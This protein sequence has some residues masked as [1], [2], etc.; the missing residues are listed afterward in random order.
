MAK[1]GLTVST[2]LDAL[3]LLL[4]SSAN[5]SDEN[6]QDVPLLIDGLCNS[7]LEEFKINPTMDSILNRKFVRLLENVKRVPKGKEHNVERSKLVIDFIQ[8]NRPVDDDDDT[9]FKSLKQVFEDAQTAYNNTDICNTTKKRIKNTL[10]W[11][12]YRRLLNSMYNHLNK[13]GDTSDA[14]TQATCLMN[15]S[16]VAKKLVESANVKLDDICTLAEERIIVNDKNSL[17]KA[18]IKLQEEET[19]GILK[20][21]LQG[22]NRMLGYRGGFARGEFVVI[23]GLQH[24]YKTGL[25]LT[26]T[27]GIC[28]YNDPKDHCKPGMKPLILF[29]SLENYARKNLYWFYKTAWAVCKGTKPDPNISLEEM[30]SFIQEWYASTGWHF[31]IERYRGSSFGHEQL[32]ETIDNYK[33]LGYEVV[34]VCLDYMSKM[35]RSTGGNKDWVDLGDLSDGIF[36]TIKSDE[37]LFITP[38]QFNRD[39]SKIAEQG[40]TNV[41]KYFG[42]S[43]VS[44][45]LEVARNADLEISV[46]IEK[47]HNKQSWL[48]VQRG[49]HRYVDDTPEKHK[50]FAYKFDPDLGI[51]DD[52]DD[53]TPRFVEDIYVLDGTE[54]AN[55]EAPVSAVF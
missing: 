32:K 35:K 28:R 31:I 2:F 36:N 48:T 4:I 49:K 53:E 9:F 37:I 13:F 16:S 11:S 14:E 23:Y 8:N 45:S 1:G 10:T 6:N 30:I 18:L 25:L 34:C 39:M 22:L 5:P 50:Y 12:K 46:Y 19:V 41:V 21:G 40:K 44:G 27:R 24:H 43:G 55:S 3:T 33:N 51:V 15:I 7:Y 29:I 38:H 26:I 47:D 17:E 20:T 54:D 52:I 42:T